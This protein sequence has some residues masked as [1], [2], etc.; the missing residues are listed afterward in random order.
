[1][2]ERISPTDN[3]KMIDEL[4]QPTPSPTAILDAQITMLVQTVF[5]GVMVSAP[6]V[7]PEMVVCS[8]AKAVGVALA[9][10]VNGDL[11]PM[12]NFRKRFKDAFSDGVAS[13]QIKPPP[14]NGQPFPPLRQ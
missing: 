4:E 14:V 5:R 12:L 1:M 9:S 6:G 8:F 7:P 10:S 11:A 13:V 3:S 2:N